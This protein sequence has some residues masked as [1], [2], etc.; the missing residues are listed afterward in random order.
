[1][2]PDAIADYWLNRV[3]GPGHATSPAKRSEL[4]DYLRVQGN[5]PGDD[6]PLDV[7]TSNTDE[8]STYQH[9]LRGLFSLVALLP[10]RMIR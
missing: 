5:A 2:T 4:V 10:E 1:L 8:W 3:Q 6:Q 9:L 7:D